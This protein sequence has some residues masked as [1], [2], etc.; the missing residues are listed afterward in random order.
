VIIIDSNLL[1]FYVYSQ[2]PPLKKVSKAQQQME[3]IKMFAAK[4]NQMNH[5]MGLKTVKKFDMKE[6]NEKKVRLIYF[7]YVYIIESFQE[8]PEWAEG[9]K[10]KDVDTKSEATEGDVAVDDEE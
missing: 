6:D 9:T 3:K 1:Y 7:D 10:K 8:K 4:A 2:K 5:R